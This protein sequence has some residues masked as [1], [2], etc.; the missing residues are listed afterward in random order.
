[1]PGRPRKARRFGGSAQ[2]QK[3]MMA[4]LVASLVAAEGIVT[5]EAKAKAM[6]PVAE[7]LITTARKGGLHNVRQVLAYLGDVEMTTKM[8]D[9]LGPRYENRPGGYTRVLKLGP[10]KGDNAPRARIELV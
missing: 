7:R 9:E 6:R 1:M 5:T 2:H 8:F 10:R 4:N 3:L